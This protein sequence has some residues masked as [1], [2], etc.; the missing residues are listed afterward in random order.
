MPHS[1]CSL[2]IK[3]QL[4]KYVRTL[5]MPAGYKSVSSETPMFLV[6]DHSQKDP[7]VSVLIYHHTH[8]HTQSILCGTEKLGF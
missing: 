6:R 3:E 1:S 2:Q 5:Q 8:P 4:L 7:A